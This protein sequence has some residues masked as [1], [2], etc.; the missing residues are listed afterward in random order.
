MN[1]YQKVV[2][3]KFHQIHIT[4]VIL[5]NVKILKLFQLF[6]ISVVSTFVFSMKRIFLEFSLYFLIHRHRFPQDHECE[7]FIEERDNLNKKRTGIDFTDLKKYG[8]FKEFSV[9]F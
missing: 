4:D 1:I 3:K 6:V 5:K 7:K 2:L 8:I 9:D